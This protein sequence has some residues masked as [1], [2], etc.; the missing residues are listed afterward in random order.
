[1]EHYE[2]F[3][4]PYS[5][6]GRH[7]DVQTVINAYK[8]T[9]MGTLCKYLNK[10][11]VGCQTE[12]GS[13][14]VYVYVQQG[15]DYMLIDKIMGG[16]SS[17]VDWR[18]IGKTLK[19]NQVFYNSRMGTMEGF[20]ENRYSTLDTLSQVYNSLEDTMNGDE[21]ILKDKIVK[22][23]VQSKNSC[24][25]D[26]EICFD[27]REPYGVKGVTIT[28]SYKSEAKCIDEKCIIH[29]EG[30][31]FVQSYL[32]THTLVKYGHSNYYIVHDEALEGFKKRFNNSVEVDNTTPDM[33]LSGIVTR[34]GSLIRIIST[35]VENFL[36][37]VAN[38]N[39]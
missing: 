9:C 26:E 12:D 11:F 14:F 23:R 36:Y 34:D 3:L 32:S 28:A 17:S 25:L 20:V 35:K 31:T 19:I 30:D 13:A 5:N 2:Y 33:N 10:D 27:T 22:N 37:Q 15:S 18:D 16:E 8:A 29:T 39:L 6:F 7:H 21:A 4:K 24:T 38:G 1:M